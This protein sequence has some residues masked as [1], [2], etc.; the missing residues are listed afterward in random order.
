MSRAETEDCSISEA[1]ADDSGQLV[2]ALERE[3]DGLWRQN[4]VGA[5][6]KLTM[7][8]WLGFA[9]A[10][11]AYVYGGMQ[12]VQKTGRCNGCFIGR[13]A[14]DYHWRRIRRR[15]GWVFVAGICSPCL[16]S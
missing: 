7:P 3:S 8:L 11:M 12:L 16:L 14:P 4:R 13:W 6:I 1:S 2:V 5:A 9:A 10:T 15:T